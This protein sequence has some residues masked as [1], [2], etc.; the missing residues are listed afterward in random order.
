L[1]IRAERL[2]GQTLQLHALSPLLTIARGY[3]VVRHEPNQRLIT[4]VKQVQAGDALSIQVQD[5]SIP[6][7]V[8]E[9][10]G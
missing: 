6:V 7:S 2:S 4:S 3:A 1:S 5:G 9:E 8:R 10:L